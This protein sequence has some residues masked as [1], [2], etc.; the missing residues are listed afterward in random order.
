MFAYPISNRAGAMTYDNRRRALHEVVSLDGW[1]DPFSHKKKLSALHVDVAFHEG[2]IGGDDPESDVIFRLK[3]KRA[4]VVVVVPEV[5]PL[6]VEKA[7]VSRDAPNKEVTRTEKGLLVRKRSASISGTLTAVP[8]AIFG[9]VKAGLNGE[10]SDQKEES[11]SSREKLTAMSVLQIMTPDGHYAWRIEPNLGDA[12]SG[13]PWNALRQPRLKLKD[14]RPIGSKSIEPGVNLEIRCRK[15]DLQ[16]WDVKLK[17]GE[18][19]KGANNLI[20]AEIEIRNRLIGS[21][22]LLDRDDF[23]YSMLTLNNVRANSL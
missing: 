2:I 16:I 15:S 17:S 5:E 23:E 6:S 7:S 14:K 19:I 12:L 11:V 1:Y 3:L 13:R 18:K 22:L 4:D 8:M 9:A 10:L 20:A 21:G